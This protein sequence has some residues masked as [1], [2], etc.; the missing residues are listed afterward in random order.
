MKSTSARAHLANKLST[1]KISAATRLIISM[2][3]LYA[4]IE[5]NFGKAILDILN[6]QYPDQDIKVT[7][8]DIGNRMM[9][10]A[11]K[12]NQNNDQRAMDS[13]QDFLTYIV[14]KDWDFAKD[15]DKW[16]EALNAII[17]NISL[18]AMSH[19]KGHS[20]RKKNEQS[21]DDA[22]GQRG[23]GG[24]N[25]EGG[26]GRMPTPVSNPLSRG[27]DDLT[28]IKRFVEIMDDM[29]PDL[30]ASL[31]ENERK[32]FDLVFFENIGGF[33][34]DIKENM[35]QA[36]AMQ[37]TYPELYEANA[38]RWSGFVGDTR[39]NLIKQMWDFIENNMEDYE[40]NI[41]KERFFSDAN[42]SD[43]RK[44]EREKLES[45][46]SVQ[47]DKDKRKYARLKWR[48]QNNVISSPDMTTF[49]NLE[50]KLKGL[51]IDVNAIEPAEDLKQNADEKL[52]AKLKWKLQNGTPT[53]GEIK[54]HDALI[55]KLQKM[56]L[57]PDSIEA[58]DPKSSKMV[59][60]K[61]IFMIAARIA[62]MV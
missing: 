53:P 22:Y 37:E 4:A 28:D 50:K 9:R 61:S 5:D 38:K 31:G 59:A 34:S 19:S 1:F 47:T 30:R 39:N 40:Y 13:V 27:L 60:S 33:T 2:F 54:K 16:E 42:P 6:E 12:Q 29:I 56:G 11:L 15:F 24:G 55:K 44:K 52:L 32:L 7:A 41:L 23:E 17:R 58:E 57:D 8:R 25:P 46:D 36:R 49:K 43:I 14:S 48:L 51:G 45:K 35:N 20:R 10:A 3:K 62:S 21:V 18:R 26:E